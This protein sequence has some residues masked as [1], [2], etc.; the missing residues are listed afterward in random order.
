MSK[1]PSKRK[2]KY[3]IIFQKKNRNTRR[4]THP[5]TTG[6]KNNNVKY[7]NSS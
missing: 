1:K 4:L 6:N 7:A 2:S 3:T 5:S